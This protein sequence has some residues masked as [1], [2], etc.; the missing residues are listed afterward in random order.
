MPLP[1]SLVVDVSEW[2]L[3]LFLKGGRPGLINM[4][5]LATQVSRLELGI[6]E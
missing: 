1:V 4:S 6:P 3:C 2:P 5:G